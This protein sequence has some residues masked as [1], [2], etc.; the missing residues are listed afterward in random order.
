VS[1]NKAIFPNEQVL[2]KLVYLAGRGSSR[3]IAHEAQGLG[4][5]ILTID[6]L[7]LRS[8]G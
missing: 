4:C 6:D 7:F 5:D 2:F 8:F 3:E 1:K